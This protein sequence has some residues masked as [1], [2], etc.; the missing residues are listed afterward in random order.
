MSWMSRFTSNSWDCVA[1]V[2]KFTVRYLW[3]IARSVDQLGNT[4][5]GGDPDET[6]SGRIGKIKRYHK[7]RIPWRRPIAKILDAGLEVI[8]DNHCVE[9]IADDEGKDALVDTQYNLPD[10]DSHQDRTG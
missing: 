5:L 3:N 7:G 8:D 10:D 2:G 1:S 6:I 4:I 9:S